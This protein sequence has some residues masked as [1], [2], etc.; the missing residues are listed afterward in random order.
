[1]GVGFVSCAPKVLLTE[2]RAYCQPG[3]HDKNTLSILR[4]CYVIKL[5][6]SPNTTTQIVLSNIYVP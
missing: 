3:P 2:H 6:A 5:R 4:H 1:M